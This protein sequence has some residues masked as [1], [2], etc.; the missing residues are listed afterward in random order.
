MIDVAEWVVA[1]Y[2][3]LKLGFNKVA[4]HY[5]YP[6]WW[7]AVRSFVMYV[8]TRSASADRLV[9]HRQAA[10]IIESAAAFGHPPTCWPGQ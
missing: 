6:G 3:D 8:W 1:S 7:K 10:A 5:Y 4:P 2:D 9:S